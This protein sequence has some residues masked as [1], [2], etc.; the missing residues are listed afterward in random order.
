MLIDDYIFYTNE[1]KKKYGE[2]TL[3]LMQ[4]GNFYEIYSIK[5]D[6]DA[7]IYKIADICNI[8]ISRKNKKINEVNK[9]NALM[10]GFPLYVIAKFQNILLQHNY[11]LVMIQQVTES[12]NVE[13]VERKVTEILSPGM[14]TNLNTK[15]SNY[16]MIIYYEKINN[17][18]IVGTSLIDV[19]TGKCFISEIASSKDDKDFANNEIVRII[20]SYNPCE[21]V[22]ISNE[23]IDDNDIKKI[24][25]I[26]HLNNNILVHYLWNSYEYIDVM[27]NKKYQEEIL[28]NVY[29]DLKS[30]LNIF[31]VLNLQYYHIGKIAFCSLLQFAYNHNADIISNIKRPEILENHRYLNLEY[32]SVLQLNII[33]LHNHEKPLIDILNRCNTAFGSRLFKERLLQPIYD[34]SELNNRYDEIDKLL[35]NNLF[36]PISK[37]LIKILDLERIKRKIIINKLHPH[38]WNGF[39]NSLNNAME[40]FKLLNLTK[41]T[42]IVEEII[43]SYEILNLENASK[44]NLN[45]IK[46]NIF[47]RGIYTDIDELEDKYIETYDKIQKL[48]DEIINIDNNGDNSFCKIEYS[49]RDGY[50]FN[51]TKKRYEY[52]KAVNGNLLSTYK[53][54]TPQQK[55]Y[56]KLTSDKLSKYTNII[57]KTITEITE[58]NTKYYKEFINKFIEKNNNNLDKIIDKLGNIDINTCNAKN[59][60][61]YKYYRPTIVDNN[62]A[63]YFKGKDIRHPIIERINSSI[64]YVGNDI[65]LSKDGI[66]LYGINASGKSCLMKTIGLNIIMAQAGMFVPA[67]DLCYQPYKHIFTRI[68]NVD[69]IYKGM[70]SFTVEMC[71]LRNILHRC[72]N[73]SLVLGDEICSGTESISGLSI[74]ASA[75]DTLV[76]KECCFIFATHLHELV[77]ISVIKN[78]IEKSKLKINH[79]HIKIEDNVIYYERKIKEGKGSNI[80][81]LEVCK[82]LDMPLNFVK[83]A[84]KIRKEVQQLD[85]FVINLNKSNYNKEVILKECKICKNKVQDTHHINFQCDS[86]ENGYFNT[87]HKNIKHNLVGLCKLCHNK[88]HNNEIIINGYIETSEGIKLDYKTVNNVIKKEYNTD[89]DIDNNDIKNIRKYI[90]VSKENKFYY[91]ETKTSKF[92]LLENNEKKIINKINKL[93]NTNYENVPQDILKKLV[94]NTL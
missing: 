15:K 42:E 11:T 88:V 14:N 10:A 32:D 85:T 31:D 69:N 91:R 75:I 24:K 66:L 34:S 29:T 3:V 65:E 52:S 73:Y 54:I 33:S 37:H 21:I 84:E 63:G 38:E 36:K 12:S 51:I 6:T 16:M 26:I 23:S 7:D 93:L 62:N 77:D 39:D 20:I 60:Y 18:Y 9:S 53:F 79:L 41:K 48:A 13:K 80:Y 59:A 78:N 74:V 28:K 45:E 44:Y 49:E 40:V 90:L 70:S 68:S 67:M 56:Y 89:K 46:G 87:F 72:D 55:G 22:F 83:N 19:S 35:K 5:D 82:A 27:E 50:H 71:E 4:V 8:T 47:N 86:D 76:K 25:E 81:G 57:N 1:Y 17:L 94:D 2:K 92:K 43:K 30:Q 58:L 61:E 64:K